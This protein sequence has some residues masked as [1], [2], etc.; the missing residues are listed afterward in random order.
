MGK[1]TFSCGCEFPIVGNE[2]DIHGDYYNAQ[3]PTG[4]EVDI[5]NIPHDCPRTWALFAEGH[6]KGVFQLEGHLGKTW[7]T[8]IQPENMEELAALVA[9]LRPGCL[10]AMSGDPPK[11]MT[12]R[13]KDRKHKLED[14]E[15]FHP[16]LEPILSTTHGV[17]CIHEDTFISMADGSEKQIKHLVPGDNTVSITQKNL[18]NTIDLCVD[19]KRSPK[20]QGVELV[21]ENG[22]SVVLTPDH[23]VQTQRGLVEV[24]DLQLDKDVVQIAQTQNNWCG[25]SPI[26]EGKYSTIHGNPTQLSYLCGQLLGDG[27][28]ASCIAAGSEDNANAIVSWLKQHFTLLDCQKRFHTRCW[29]VDIKGNELLIHQNYGNRK[30]SYRWFAEQLGL[31]HTKHDKT[32]HPE[33]FALSDTCRRAF[34]AGLF[35]ADG[36]SSENGCH[37]CSDNPQVINGIRKLLSLDGI[38]TYVTNDKKHIHIN[39][40][41]LFDKLIGP[42]LLCKSIV[43]QSYGITYGSFPKQ[44]L[45][46]YIYDE[47][48][49]NLK[50]FAKHHDICDRSVVGKGFVNMRTARKAGMDFGDV[51]YMRVKQIK[52][53]KQPQRFYSI[54][55]E[56]NHNLIANGIVL[57]NNC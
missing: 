57:D 41:E 14:V 18:L 32:I 9:L 45:K 42:F 56:H 40:A 28:A 47:N 8:K 22:Y 5:Y 52:Q 27:C 35:D 49:T 26:E 15:Y 21:L 11:S 44:E 30:T 33:I 4:I 1:L 17:L 25:I 3:L 19:I 20:T 10:R 43:V 50:K 13:F 37:Y 54:S 7:A 16:L 34:L 38:E 2:V 6:T 39:N 29:Y 31:N 51:S 36:H 48:Y 53:I 12:Q 55:I 46:T 23:K 24:Q